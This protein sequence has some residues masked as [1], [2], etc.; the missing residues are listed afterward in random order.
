MNRTVCSEVW[1]FTR[2]EGNVHP[3]YYKRDGRWVQV[4]KEDRL[5]ETLGLGLRGLGV[6]KGVPVAIMSRTRYEWVF[7]DIAILSVGGIVVGVHDSL[8]TEEVRY[9]VEHSESRVVVLEND[10]MLEKHGQ[11]LLD[12]P[13]VEHLV[14]IEPGKPSGD[15]RILSFKE[16]A[17][18]G[19]KAR[20]ADPELFG[21]LVEQVQPDDVATYMYTSGTTGKPKAVMLTHKNLFESARAMR[22]IMPLEESDVSLIFLPLSH[23]LQ[24]MSLYVG[25]D[26]TC[27]T[28][29]YAESIDKLVENIAEVRPSVMVCVPRIFEKIHAR[30][31]EKVEALNP[32]RRAIFNHFLRVGIRV[33]ELRRK[34]L[35]VPPLLAMRYRIAYRLSLY[36]VNQVLGGRTKYLASGG[37]PLAPEIAEFFSACNVLVLE[38]YGLSETSSAASVNR[39]EN[40]KFG[41]V[42]KPLPGTEI[43]IATDGEILI[44]GPGVFQGYL[45][46]EEE[47]RA[48]FKDGWFHTGDIGYL[49][50]DDF[51]VITDRK[52]DIIVTAQG[53]NIAPQKIENL[54]KQEP[55][56]GQVMVHGDQRKFLSALITIDAEEAE[57]FAQ[58]QGTTDWRPLIQKEIDRIVA[59]VNSS[60][61]SYEQVKKYRILEEDFT[62]EGGELT[63]TLKVKRK[64][65]EKR[66]SGILDSF[67]G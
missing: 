50:E 38:G 37:A 40:Y 1:E 44:K 53:K 17:A 30:V 27:G 36:R 33:A 20:E 31:M 24:R 60:L 45:K 41:T 6:E 66:Y 26:G 2:R 11:V 7:L 35:P 22:R 48:V 5:A 63:P 46:D 62:V 52:K 15:E 34:G 10:A 57:Y 47:T 55:L 32:V 61:P 43:R 51:L 9:I 49:E 21:R 19:E 42:G 18:R 3:Q 14:V 58:R 54:L 29:Y 28:A 25:A 65:V 4:D 13:R 56:I 59:R 64:V 12:C 16:L 67:Y 8:P 23:I 39:Y